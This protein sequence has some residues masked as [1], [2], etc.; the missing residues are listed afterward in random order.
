MSTALTVPQSTA[1][2]VEPA[3]GDILTSPA[4]FRTAMQ[5]AEVLASSP[6]VP[7]SFR[8]KPGDVFSAMVLARG[9]GE[10]LFTVL[11]AVHFVNGKPGFSAQFMI[12]R[13]NKCGTFAGPIEFEVSGEG[14]SL[15]VTCSAHLAH[16][17][18]LVEKTVTMAM[19][20]ADGWTKNPKYGSLG[21]QMLSYRAATFLI[22]LY[23]P[24]ILFGMR[25]SDELED[26]AAARGEPVQAEYTEPASQTPRVSRTPQHASE[27]VGV[28]SVSAGSS[29][30]WQSA[31]QGVRAHAFTDTLL[32]L[33]R[34][35]PARRSGLRSAR[36]RMLARP[37]R[38]WA[39]LFSGALAAKCRCD[40]LA[41]P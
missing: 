8:N 26:I 37:T 14:A 13:A 38:L 7:Q 39:T 4:A 12:A 28:P 41:A 5:M 40:R 19:A 35:A 32:M 6:L 2:A 1:L 15:A 18:K 16:T 21:E 31:R 29:R 27:G 22:R 24:E 33:Q 30:C 23:C 11:H 34:S 25:P 9:M 10:E 3:A 17:G 20:K 36:A